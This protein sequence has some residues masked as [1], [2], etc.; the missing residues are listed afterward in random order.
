MRERPGWEEVCIRIWKRILIVIM[1]RK[2]GQRNTETL[3]LPHMRPEKELRQKY[4][5]PHV[6]PEKE[7]SPKCL[8][9]HVK[10]EKKLLESRIMMHMEAKMMLRTR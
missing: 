2:S 7:L 10:P 5:L 4:L 3:F 1:C 6:K 9:P 8:L